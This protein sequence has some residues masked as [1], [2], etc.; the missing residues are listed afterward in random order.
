MLRGKAS[1]L[2]SVLFL[3]TAAASAAGLELKKKAGDLDVTVTLAKNPPVVGKNIIEIDI[4]DASGTPVPGAKVLVN[5][6]MP[7]MP[8]MAPMNYRVEAVRKGGTYRARLGLIMAG[9]WIV[10]VKIT[11][12]GKTVTAKF[13]FDAR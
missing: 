4:R 1:R 13:N 10:A 9:P 3:I 7:P 2:V 5:Y 11:R 8:R 12:E 6:Y